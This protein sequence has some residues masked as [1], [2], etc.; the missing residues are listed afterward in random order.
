MQNFKQAVLSSVILLSTA[1][2]DTAIAVPQF[3]STKTTDNKQIGTDLAD[4]LPREDTDGWTFFD[5]YVRDDRGNVV[6]RY[7]GT[8]DCKQKSSA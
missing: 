4:G 1:M 5:Y 7:G 8:K 6:K 2:M 3:Y